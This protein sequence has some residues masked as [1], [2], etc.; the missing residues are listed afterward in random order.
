MRAPDA[1]CATASRSFACARP[2]SSGAR[3][4]LRA[5]NYVTFLVQALRVGLEARAARRRPRDDR[6][7]GDRR[8]SRSLVARRF[9]A[10]L[11]VVSQDVFPETA[12]RLGRLDNRRSSSRC[13]ACSCAA[14]LRRADRVV[15]IGETM[16]ARLVAKGARAD[17]V[18]RDPELGRHERAHAGRARQRVGA[19]ARARRRVRRHALGQRRARAGPRLAHPRGDAAGR[20]RRPRASRSSAAARGT[21]SSSR[22]RDSLD[23][24]QRRASCRTSRARC[25]RS[26]SPRR[27]C[28][29]SG[30]RAGSRATSFRA[31]CTASSPSARPVIAPRTRRARP[32]RSSS[33]SAA[34]SSFRLGAPICSRR[35]SG[36][37]TPGSS[38]S[39]RWAAR[40]RE[41]VM[42]EADRSVAVA[43]YRDLLADVA[44]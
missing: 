21:P 22:S 30:W 14:Y 8:T 33:A 32:R 29:S 44:R 35:R 42:R 27:T 40:G 19:G 12:V 37:P 7:A 1:R 4:W 20:S 26:R 25:S 3:L 17:R 9:R 31:G 43:R 23:A 2:R 38:T 34:A 39:P 10:P 18:D 41:Y 36:A 5:L 6:P 11:V 15:A 28:T 16:R 24:R 13:C